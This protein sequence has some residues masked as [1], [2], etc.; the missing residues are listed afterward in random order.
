M[1][2]LIFDGTDDSINDQWTTARLVDETALT[3]AL[4]KE[5]IHI[6][7]PREENKTVIVH[8]YYHQAREK[9]FRIPLYKDAMLFVIR[10]SDLT[11][12]IRKELYDYYQQAGQSGLNVVLRLAVMR[13]FENLYPEYTHL[14]VMKNLKVRLID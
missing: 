14:S 7:N 3:L 12:K 2:S 6:K 5:T 9:I 1:T 10:L 4:I 8:K 11:E 13:I